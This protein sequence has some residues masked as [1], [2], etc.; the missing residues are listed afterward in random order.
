MDVVIVGPWFNAMADLVS[1]LTI[2]IAYSLDQLPIID[3]SKPDVL[4][5]VSYGTMVRTKRPVSIHV[6]PTI[7][8]RVS[9]P[10]KRT[11]GHEP[12]KDT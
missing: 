10:S 7:K 8:G 4:S 3:D 6:M 2:D 5:D 11:A 1:Q 12:S 9:I